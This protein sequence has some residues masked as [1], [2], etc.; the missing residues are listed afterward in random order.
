MIKLVVFDMA[1]TTV[2]EDNVVYK[3]VRDAINA[4][5]YEFSLEQ[6]LTHGAGK[7]KSKAIR[8]VL[9]L[10]QQ[11]H[12]EAEVESIFTDFKNRLGQ[13]YRQLDVKG[14]PGA[15]DLFG[16]LRQRNIQVVLN[17]GYDRSTA[18]GL[19]EKIGWQIGVDIDG[20]VTASDVETGRPGPDMI[21]RA[22]ELTGIESA[23]QV[24]KIGD[25]QIDIHEGNNA[26]CGLTVGITTGAHTSEQLAAANPSAVIDS[27]AE[28]TELLPS[29]H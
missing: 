12:S 2:D 15:A 5:G 24:A 25:S 7:E 16:E 28:F 17:T 21:L 6:V 26:K 3:T 23:E 19:V 20:L 13:A 18:E 8:D 14:M 10:D 27:L 11:A 22:M 1:G 4:A 9:C 29:N